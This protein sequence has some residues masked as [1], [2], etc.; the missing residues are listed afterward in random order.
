MTL[1]ETMFG[2]K[3]T[4]E[5][6]PPPIPRPFRVSGK[7]RFAT[8][9]PI[10][11]YTVDEQI[12]RRCPTVLISTVDKFAM[13]PYLEDSSSIFG[14]VDSLHRELGYGRTGVSEHLK[15]S[16]CDMEAMK[17]FLPPSL[18]IQDE[19]HLIEGP[20]GSMVGIYETG[21]EILTSSSIHRPKYIASSATIKE[22]AS[23]VGSIFRRQVSVF[24]P[25]GISVEDSYFSESRE[26]RR[27]ISEQA[28]RLYLGVSSTK[29]ST[30]NA[31]QN[32]EHAS[33]RTVQNQKQP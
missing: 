10:S 13:L 28:G 7:D 27:S 1:I 3:K 5:H 32:L 18:I 14:N 15:S 8:F 29:Q 12:Y 24:P 16:G 21:M 6:R 33:W 20:L 30:C 23:Q 2:L 4:P 31:H 19:L 11:A 26:D 25:I 9:M 17:P 22:S